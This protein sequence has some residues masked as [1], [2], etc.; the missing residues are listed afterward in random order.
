MLTG[1]KSRRGGRER[2]GAERCGAFQAF[3][4][5]CDVVNTHGPSQPAAAHL[6]TGPHRLPKRCLL[7]R[8]MIEDLHNLQIAGIREGNDAIP[9]SE[10]GME[11]TFFEISTQLFGQACD[12]SFDALWSAGKD[13]VIDAHALILPFAM[14][15]VPIGRC[16]ML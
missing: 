4:K 12:I 10:P 7:G 15:H 2:A 9:G 11:T 8:G 13:D 3:L 5:G 14:W 16:R 6:G 1:W